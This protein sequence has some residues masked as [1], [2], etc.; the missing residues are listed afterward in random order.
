MVV[1]VKQYAS[2]HDDV[3]ITWWC[4]YSVMHRG[5]D[6]AHYALSDF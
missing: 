2:Q 3:R 4:R 1:V 5:Y 6:A